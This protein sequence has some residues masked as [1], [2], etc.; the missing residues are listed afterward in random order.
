[1]F[2][3][4]SIVV[5]RIIVVL[6]LIFYCGCSKNEQKTKT[7]KEQFKLPSLLLETSW[8]KEN[9]QNKNILILDARTKKE[10]L[11]DHIPGAISFPV[12]ELNS[13]APGEEKNLKNI[14]QIN[15]LFS[16]KGISN[17]KAI[18]IYADN[19]MRTASRLFWALELHGHQ[20]TGILNGGFSGWLSSS[21]PVEKKENLPQRSQFVTRHT[22][23]VV[24]KIEVN[25][26]LKKEDV[27]IVDS[28]S[29]SEY[30][31]KK[32]KGKRK[33][34]IPTAELF[35]A[36]SSFSSNE[37]GC[38]MK[39]V[40]ELKSLYSSIDK[41]KKV[42]LYCNSGR[43]ATVNYLA[44]RLLGIDAAVYDGSWLEWSA[45]EKLPVST[46]VE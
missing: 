29:K 18:V 33:G 19:H 37:N 3:R 46:E 25:R 26:A 13:K 27:I 43:S 24:D 16:L 39:D 12:L 31:G 36:S 32:S 9:L 45:D 35:S 11:E 44:M 4:R 1:M 42:Y 40:D 5:G 21:Y 30:E 2:N 15:E 28:R 6:F 38:F 17:D 34:H 23:S 7:Q 20:N 10:Y 14:L 8:L 22:G 41:S